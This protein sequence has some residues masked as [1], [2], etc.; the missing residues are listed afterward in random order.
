[1]MFLIGNA[2]KRYH[3]ACQYVICSKR[4]KN[5]RSIKIIFT[6]FIGMISTTVTDTRCSMLSI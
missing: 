1:M 4:D 2:R 3:G 6:L 5:K